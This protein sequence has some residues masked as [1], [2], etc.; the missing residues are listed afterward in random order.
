MNST[1]SNPSRLASLARSYALSALGVATLVAV[2]VGSRLWFETPNFSAAGAVALFAGCVLA[3]RRLALAT[4]V[5]AM[6]VSDAL[7]GFYGFDNPVVMATVYLAMCINVALGRT[8]VRPAYSRSLDRVSGGPGR[9]LALLGR[10]IGA[11]LLG[12]VLFFLCTNFA[13]W[14]TDGLYALTLAGL[15]ECYTLA[16]PFFRHTITSDALFVSLL[17]S[18]LVAERLLSAHRASVARA[19]PLTH[20]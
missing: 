10:A 7:L 12:S 6:L 5:L 9:S 17:F 18:G 8:V 15:I 4:A 11:G 2:A 16:L 3:K 19:A 13:V 14:A 20:A 1:S